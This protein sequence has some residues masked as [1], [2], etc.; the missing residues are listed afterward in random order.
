M[1]VTH[2]KLF[3]VRETDPTESELME[4]SR[5]RRRWRVLRCVFK[6]LYLL[7]NNKPQLVHNIDDLIEDVRSSPTLI[8]RS[9]SR[10]STTDAIED[11]RRHEL[12][13]EAIVRGSR[14]D[15]I[16]IGRI[17]DDDPKRYL[18]SKNDPE[19]MQNR[20]NSKGFRPIYEA[21]KY[22]HLEVMKLLYDYGADPRL[23]SYIA[24]REQENALDV[25]CRWSH[26]GIV[27]WLLGAVKWSKRELKQASAIC[28]NNELQ[29][30]VK[31]RM[32]R[33]NWLGCCSRN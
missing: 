19:A 10:S 23:L 5:A 11:H 24:D 31:A 33:S 3:E 7:Q 15:C 22:G 8:G 17:L 27:S 29:R 14:D 21:A 25:A 1:A 13:F 32:P 16:E 28:T 20:P 4:D 9:R 12:L 30:Q 2:L 6:G 26:A 18:R